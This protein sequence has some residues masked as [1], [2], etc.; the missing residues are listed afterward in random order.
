M[1]KPYFEE[2]V[3]GRWLLA[4]VLALTLMNSGVSVAFSYLSRDFWTTLNTK[5][6]A[7][8]QQVLLKFSGALTLGVPVSVFYGFQ[9][10]KLA[11]K[12]REW[13]TARLLQ[14]YVGS[15]EFRGAYYA[16]ETSRGSASNPSDALDNPDQRLAEDVSAFTRSSLRFLI[17]ILRAVIDLLSF[18]AILWSIYPPLFGVIVVYASL[19]T[20]FTVSI[21][22]TLVDLNYKQLQTEADFRFGLVRLRQNAEAIAFYKGEEREAQE[23][24]Y[25]LSSA[26]D[27]RNKVIAAE[28]NLDFF[29]TAYSFLIQV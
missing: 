25:R 10:E 29:T 4:G 22:K 3:E 26:V 17:A 20:F 28:R 19:G 11:I 6:A 16:L 21:G 15:S 2:E 24:D 23:L 5:D 1:A 14:L 18:S 27:N 8:F 7:A 12:W 13:M 9:R